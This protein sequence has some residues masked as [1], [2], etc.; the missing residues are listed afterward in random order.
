MLFGRDEAWKRIDHL[1][2][3]L[4]IIIIKL[5]KVFHSF[6]L[7]HIHLCHFNNNN[8]YLLRVQIYFGLKRLVKWR[9]FALEII[10]Q[11][12]FSINRVYTANVLIHWFAKSLYAHINCPPYEYICRNIVAIYAPLKFYVN[13][14]SEY[15]RQL[16]FYD[17]TFQFYTSTATRAI[18]NTANETKSLSL[19]SH[20]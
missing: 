4:D 19:S 3:R 11:I 6:Q 14:Y 20:R 16:N 13:T 17:I 8:N 5:V 12:I 1:W 10:R 15:S 2:G 18:Y 7:I 9:G